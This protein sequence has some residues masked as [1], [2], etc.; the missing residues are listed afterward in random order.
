MTNFFPFVFLLPWK[1]RFNFL[2]IFFEGIFGCPLERTV[3]VYGFNWRD[4]VC[5][6]LT[7]QSIKWSKI[8]WKYIQSW[9]L[10]LFDIRRVW[11][12]QRSLQPV[13]VQLRLWWRCSR[14]LQR[15]N[16]YIH[17]QSKTLLQI[18]CFSKTTVTGFS[19]NID[20]WCPLKSAIFTRKSWV[21]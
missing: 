1:T 17:L 16:I 6:H 5:V 20:A 4:N 14:S 8:I 19:W 7:N 2:H 15:D 3:C 21:N 18:K 11:F 12:H 10:R 9:T 13:K